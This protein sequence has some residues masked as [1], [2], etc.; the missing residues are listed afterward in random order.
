MKGRQVIK[1]N[2]TFAQDELMALMNPVWNTEIFGTPVIKHITIEDY[3]A[4]PATEFY[5]VMIY[6]RKNKV[7][8]ITYYTK[9][10][11]LL[12]M[13][14]AV[15]SSIPGVTAMVMAEKDRTTAGE[16]V[17]LMVTDEMKKILG[18]A[19]YLS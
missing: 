18:D 12:M 4:L 5:Q 1:T 17:L 16:K 2:K 15:A 14:G 13:T 10:G 8:L 3:I 6:P 7:I 11:G 19:G 9:S